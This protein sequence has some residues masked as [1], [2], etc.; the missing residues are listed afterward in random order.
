MKIGIMGG[1]FNPIHNAHIKMAEYVLENYGFDKII[2]IPAYKPPHKDYQDNMCIHRYNMVK[3]AIQNY[4]KFEISDIE[5][6]NEGKSY[7]YLTALEL[8]KQYDIDG[9]I[10]FIIG[11]DAFEKIETWYETDK[12]KKLVDFIVFIREN[13]PV[14]F[15]DLRKKG[16]NFE[17]A[18]MNFVDISSTELRERIQKDET[19]ENLIPKEVEEYIKN[20][21]LY[22]NTEM[23]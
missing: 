22:R 17:F 14:N 18:K 19:V 4:P 2:F 7:S 9:K 13:E 6:K 15:D 23:A 5:Y 16:Y 20:N 8:Y 1:T 11:T 10:N 21:G 12:F 3:L